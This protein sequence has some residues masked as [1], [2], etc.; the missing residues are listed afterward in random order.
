[1]T[2]RKLDVFAFLYFAALLWLLYEMSADPD[3]NKRKLARLHWRYR[4]L[5]RTAERIG[6]LGIQAESEYLSAVELQRTT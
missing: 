6:Q 5:Q 1:M 3:P 2:R 4:Y